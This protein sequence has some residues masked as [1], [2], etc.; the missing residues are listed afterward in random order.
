MKLGRGNA[1]KSQPVTLPERSQTVML[2]PPTGVRIPARVLE[3]GPDTLL[4]AIM[5]PT[6]P[7]SHRQLEGLML[8][9]VGAYGR[10]RLSGT[11]EIE[12][13]SDPDVLRIDR[14]RSIEVLQE[15]EYVRVRCA[16]PVLVCGGTDQIPVQS[17]TVDISGGGLL[18][19]GP[20]SLRVGD[21]VQFQLTLTPGEP[22]VGGRGTVV[23][24]DAHGHRAVAFSSI[25]DFDRRRL[26]RFIFE[27]QRAERHRGR[28]TDDRYGD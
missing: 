11:T 1:E 7:L 8:E 28:E 4:V 18:L 27:L 6:A 5:V 19:A 10:A 24:V 25:S 2:I 17:F 14:P 21:D 23:R 15:R 3:C 13:P 26:V 9:F 20:A 12:D 22:L 16:R